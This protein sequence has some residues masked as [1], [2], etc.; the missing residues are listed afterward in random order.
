MTRKNSFEH[1][2]NIFKAARNKNTSSIDFIDF[3]ANINPLGLADNVRE[4]IISSLDKIIHYP[5]PDAHDLKTA[6]SKYYNVDYASITVGNGAVELLYVLCHLVKPKRVLIPAP[7]FSEYERAAKASKAEV[8]YYYL[9]ENTNFTIDVSKIIPIMDEF[10]IV[11]IGNPNNPTGTILP[12]KDL[13]LLIRSAQKS[14]CLVVVDES[15]I[16]FLPDDNQHTCRDLIKSYDNL[17]ILHSLTKFYAIPGLR[18]GFTLTSTEL[19]KL[20][21]LGKDPWNANTLA[22]S[23]GVAALK[24]IDYRIKTKEIIGSAK[25][26]FY[27]D[28]CSIQGL[29]VHFPSVNFILI[30]IENT[31]LMSAELSQRMYERGFLI[32]DCAN[33]PGLSPFYIRLAVKLPVQNSLIIESLKESIVGDE[34]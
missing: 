23:A 21:D 19:A 2:G 15:F 4:S 27:K 5:D 7:S 31:G 26:Q 9:C 14:N 28:L 13:E 34:E 18:L 11:F 25:Q 32:R 8:E 17:V 20:L 6:I 30:N 3:S 1:G 10:D 33:Y 12:K 24:N 29:K 22:Q 16:D